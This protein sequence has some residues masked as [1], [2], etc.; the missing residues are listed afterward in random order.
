ME[1]KTDDLYSDMI[2]D[3]FWY[4]F[5]EYPVNA[6]CFENLELTREVIEQL[7]DMNRKAYGK[8]KDETNSMPITR[9]LL[10]MQKLRIRNPGRMRRMQN[11][12]PRTDVKKEKQGSL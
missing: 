3:P 12:N 4:D 8:M 6:Q 11:H 2:N 10:K 1:I 7:R 5:S 9:Y